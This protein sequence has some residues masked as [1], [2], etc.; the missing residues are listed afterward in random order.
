MVVIGLHGYGGHS[1]VGAIDGNHRGLREASLGVVL[2]NHWVDGDGG[3]YEQDDEI[4]L[5]AD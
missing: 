4:H 5:E 3:D 2:L 1:K